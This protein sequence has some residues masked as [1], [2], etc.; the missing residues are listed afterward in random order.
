MLIMIMMLQSCVNQT[1]LVV[2]L[3]SG[4]SRVCALGCISFGGSHVMLNN[5]LSLLRITIAAEA[6]V[7]YIILLVGVI[8]S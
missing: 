5:G 2:A 6:I 7:C 4:M 1:P 3:D 8:P